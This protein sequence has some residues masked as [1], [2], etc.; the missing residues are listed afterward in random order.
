MYSD[1]EAFR[2]VLVQSSGAI[3]KD[4]SPMGL[5]QKG[6]G[7]SMREFTHWKE[8]CLQLVRMKHCNLVIVECSEYHPA[9]SP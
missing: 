3:C 6:S 2:D 7:K 1:P 8:E 9:T 4:Y 5:G